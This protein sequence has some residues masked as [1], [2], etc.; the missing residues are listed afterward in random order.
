M[1]EPRISDVRFAAARPDMRERGMLGWICC[2]VDQNLQLDGLALRRTTEGRYRLSF[3]HHVDSS[4][5]K[6][7][8]I[9]PLSSRVRD[10]IE[11]QVIDALRKR[12]FVA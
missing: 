1:H 10:A 4:G 3:P 9:K 6:H 7:D 5:T 2:S 11:A 8:L 12:G